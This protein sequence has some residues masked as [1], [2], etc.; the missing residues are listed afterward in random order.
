MITEIRCLAVLKAGQYCK[1]ISGSAQKGTICRYCKPVLFRP[2]QYFPL[3][4]A[5]SFQVYEIFFTN[6]M[7]FR[8]GPAIYYITFG[9]LKRRG[10]HI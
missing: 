9:D 4:V 3:S 10:L 2:W 7:S 8:D 6:A 1:Q 5:C